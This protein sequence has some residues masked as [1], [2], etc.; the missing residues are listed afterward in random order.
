M[1]DEF[2]FF[3]CSVP[4][5]AVLY[6]TLV[7]EE[8]LNSSLQYNSKPEDFIC[9]VPLLRLQQQS[10]SSYSLI[11]IITLYLYSFSL[12]RKTILEMGHP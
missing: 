12:C 7:T 1:R 3:S 8:S 4:A 5:Q 6:R 10:L 9:E 2:W 11:G